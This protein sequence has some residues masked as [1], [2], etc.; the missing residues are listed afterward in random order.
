M[1][2][3]HRHILLRILNLRIVVNQT[4]IYELKERQPLIIPCPEPAIQVLITNGF[5]HSRLV[6]IKSRP[7]ICFYEVE[8]LI[9]NIQLL[10]GLV[11]TLFFFTIYILTGILFFILFANVPLIIM[12]VIFYI[13][14]NDF[15]RVH[16]LKTLHE[17]I[18][19]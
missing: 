17:K 12:L 16:S 8:G 6:K 13:M 3:R 18:R 5:H 19:N 14:R 10:T 15:I 9:D 1:F 7:G 4:R 11:L 2:L